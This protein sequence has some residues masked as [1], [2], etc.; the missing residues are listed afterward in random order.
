MKKAVKRVLIIIAVIIILVAGTGLYYYY[1]MMTMNPAETGQ[2]PGANIYAVKNVINSVYFIKTGNGY[3]LVDSGSDL[4]KLEAAIKPTGIDASDVKWI[5][6][7]HSDYDHTA[8]LPLFPN[9]A[10]YMSEDELPLINGTKKRTF[11]FGNKMPPGIDINKINLLTDGQELSCY[12]T[13]VKCIKAPGHTIGSMAY[14]VDGRYLFSGDA[15]KFRDGKISVHPYT[16]D[17]KTAQ[18]TIEQ[19][20][21]TIK[22]SSIVFTAHYVYH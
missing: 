20:A 21:E 19:L 3:I 8:G 1:P 18:K 15:F 5:L 13:K 14:L 9:A 4:K 10:I 7:T 17:K 11:V 16:M 2:V 12:D 22:N 6:L